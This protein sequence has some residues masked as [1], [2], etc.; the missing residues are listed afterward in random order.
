M[1]FCVLQNEK[2]LTALIGNMLMEKER[3]DDFTEIKRKR[4]L[5]D[6]AEIVEVLK[7]KF[8][9]V[10]NYVPQLPELNSDM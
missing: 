8:G 2:G 9:V 5:K 6:D 10:L 4:L 3:I 1:S 7:D